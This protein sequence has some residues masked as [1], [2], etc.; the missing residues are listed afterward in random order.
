MDQHIDLSLGFDPGPAPGDLMLQQEARIR[1]IGPSVPPLATPFTPV[2]PSNA[3]FSWPLPAATP[4]FPPVASHS[5]NTPTSQ[6]PPLPTLQPVLSFPPLPNVDL[7]PN[8]KFKKE[9]I[10]REFITLRTRIAELQNAVVSE[11]QTSHQYHHMIVAYHHEF[12]QLGR[13]LSQY[14][15]RLARLE[16][17][18]KLDPQLGRAKTAVVGD[19]NDSESDD[20]LGSDGEEN[21]DADPAAKDSDGVDADES[22]SEV[23]EDKDNKALV[24]KAKKAAA[25]LEIKRLTTK[26]FEWFLG[27]T[28]LSSKND[29]PAYEEDEVAATLPF[30]SGSTTVRQLRFDWNSTARGENK[31]KL[32]TMVRFAM[33]HGAKIVSDCEENLK[34][35]G[36]VGLFDRFKIKYMDLRRIFKGTAGQR[37][38]GTA[39][40]EGLPKH[41]RN[42]R[43]TGKLTVR[44]RKRA[45]AT[46]ENEWVKETKYDVAFNAIFMSDDENEYENGQKKDGR[47]IS[48]APEYRSETLTKLFDTVDALNDPAPSNQYTQ[49]IRGE[50]TD[51]GIPKIK[52]KENKPRYWMIDR[53]WLDKNGKYDTVSYILENG[54]EWAEAVDP[55]EIEEHLQEV[56]EAKKQNKRKIQGGENEKKKKKQKSANQKSSKVVKGNPKKAVT[57]AKD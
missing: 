7:G 6:L 32:E 18:G 39:E 46:G 44:E 4:S 57:N 9:D 56:R 23:D 37:R 52:L 33:D 29:L 15:E 12:S 22:E 35:A 50:T 2:T 49:R 34:L 40:G 10:I 26:I 16:L 48:R 38:S 30:I 8:A 43:A 54:R 11:R 51:Q 5:F 1:P 3:S 14:E 31:I 28:S 13:R 45:S 36:E 19:V 47:F 27:A 42:A 41:I 53:A 20:L 24:V 55:D 21:G 25:S 17:D